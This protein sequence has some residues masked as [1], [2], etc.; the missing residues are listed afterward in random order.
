[1]LCC[2]RAHSNT[3]VSCTDD[4]FSARCYTGSMLNYIVAKAENDVIGSKND[5]PWYLPADLIHFKTLT[6]GHTVVM[7]R[8][9]FDSILARLGK[10]LPERTNVVLTRN[11][12]FAYPGV[13]VLHDIAD[14]DTLEGEVFN[15]G[16]E[17]L[18][19]ATFDR[20]DKLYAT[21]VHADIPGDTYF[22]AIEADQWRETAREP[23]EADE[24]NPYDYD[25]V[26]YERIT[27]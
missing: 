11:P 10:P 20:A 2:Q 5:L 9:T 6:L 7:G 14:I 25:F 26:T 13:T 23:H 17:E 4:C 21:E 1:M 15:I 19:R 16:G 22:P 8:K 3:H 27:A 24:K 12:D 18:F